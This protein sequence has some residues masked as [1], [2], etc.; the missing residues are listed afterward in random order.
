MQN[1]RIGTLTLG[2]SLVLL[3]ILIPIGLFTDLDVL[4]VL[5]LSPL[6]LIALGG[7]I[8]YF[9]VRRKD[10]KIKYDGLS[11]FM[12]ICITVVTLIGS[13]IQPMIKRG[14]ELTIE[15]NA[16]RSSAY[17]KIENV[18]ADFNESVY[19]HVYTTT[20]EGG[21]YHA[22]GVDR[23]IVT[24]INKPEFAIV[25]DVTMNMSENDLTKEQ[26]VERLTKLFK[27]VQN[28]GI[29]NFAE[30]SVQVELKDKTYS[31]R[32]NTDKRL[33][34]NT[35]E[36]IADS[37]KETIRNDN[38]SDWEEPSNDYS[39]EDTGSYSSDPSDSS[40]VS[41]GDGSESSSDIVNG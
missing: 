1:R 27:A 23:Y 17:E 41:D 38:V 6:L 21:F 4:F 33:T 30:V 35:Y 31:L 37:V 34:A 7:E 3:G 9:A 11:V 8:V 25:A 22:D 39:D 18:L 16:S 2:I 29:E 40:T 32:A 19:A 14:M 13:S 12:I 28:S 24:G 15:S 10:E 20:M 5:R 36:W 26:V